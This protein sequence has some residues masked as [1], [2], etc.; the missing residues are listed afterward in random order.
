MAAG[1]KRKNVSSFKH[2]DTRINIPTANS[3]KIMPE[4]DKEPSVFSAG[5]NPGRRPIRLSWD[6]DADPDPVETLAMPLYIHEKLHPGDF[7][8][9][10]LRDATRQTSLHEDF[11]GLVPDARFD[12]YKYRGN[13]QNRIIHGESRHVMASLLKKESMHGKVQMIYFDP[14]YGI[15]FNKMFQADVTDRSNR[16]SKG[17]PNDLE[18][19]KAFR[20]DYQR[21]LHSYFD[22]IYRIAMLSKLLLSETGSFFLQIG[23]YNLHNIA[24]ILDEVFDIE[25]RVSTITFKKSSGT[26][27]DMIPEGSDYILWYA[28]DIS[29][30]KK[31]YSQLYEKLNNKELV[32]HLSSY[33]MIELNEEIDYK[34]ISVDKRVLL[35]KK[36][37]MT[38]SEFKKKY[39]NIDVPQ[40]LKKMGARLFR[41]SGLSSQNY[42]KEKS[43]PY[44]WNGRTYKVASNRQ[45]SIGHDGLDILAKKDLLVAVEGGELHY[46]L[47]S[48]EIPGRRINNLWGSTMSANDLHYVVE[49]AESVVERCMLMTTRPGDIVLDPTCGSGTSAF[50]AEAWGRRW[51]TIDTSMTAI[52]LARQR[53]M[54]GAH[55][56]Q[57]LRDSPTGRMI[58]N[59]LRK[60]VGTA[61]L[62]QEEKYG[63]D[64]SKGF[65]LERI[66]RV[67]P[68]ILSGKHKADVIY[69]P[70]R[71]KIMRNVVRVTSPFTIESLQRYSYVDAEKVLHSVKEEEIIMNTRRAIVEALSRTGIRSGNDNVPV[72]YIEDYG[73]SRGIT[74]TGTFE[75]QKAGI[76]IA[77]DDCTVPPEMVN[78]AIHET[79]LHPD[80]KHVIIVAF[81]YTD[82]GQSRD[83]QIKGRLKVHRVQANLDFMVGNIADS[84]DDASFVMIGE[85]DVGVE[86]YG[87]GEEITVRINGYNTY[88]PTRHQTEFADRDRIYCWM[89]DTDYDEHSFFAR[90]IFFPGAK[91]GDK[92]IERMLNSLKMEIDM[93]RWCNIREIESL[94]FERPKGGK[95]A[96]KIVT[97][98]NTEMTVPIDI[99]RMYP[100][101]GRARR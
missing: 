77:P 19:I 5:G 99:D 46:K 21:G 38:L 98:T 100:R 85:P 18:F 41:R 54:F 2:K 51:I 37:V 91:S 61:P 11:N 101:R 97:K 78:A 16:K 68:G 64:P 82:T 30:A 44:K 75:G 90:K 22:N 89:I 74:H 8:E 9:S 3:A 53:L 20:D 47:Y 92:Q 73:G 71:P 32:E 14:P 88:N 87:D 67:N 34:N 23:P 28:K 48:D 58:E 6:R 12:F 69:H 60:Q 95:I 29:K 81:A 86:L 4:E 26:S 35:P 94:P 40:D 80:A 57:E 10:L 52:T 1:K 43:K 45:W 27:S 79:A 65:V 93:E 50:V 72:S 42:D 15:K 83:A 7:I 25:N 13:W 39:E 96:V 31:Q 49:T 76:L 56:Y 24:V 33:A 63:N 55:K 62:P 66:L 84:P 70:D 36:K 17:F 59:R